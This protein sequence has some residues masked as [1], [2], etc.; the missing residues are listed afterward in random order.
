MT[1]PEGWGGLPRGSRRL[2]VRVKR[3]GRWTQGI[4]RQKDRDPERRELEREKDRQTQ[5]RETLVTA[6]E[7]MGEL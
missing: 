6:M 7:Q 4:N 2:G 1:R 5:D 3:H